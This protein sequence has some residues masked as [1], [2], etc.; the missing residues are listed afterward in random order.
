MKKVWMF[1]LALVFSA[2][3]ALAGGDVCRL[4]SEGLRIAKVDSAA[5]SMVVRTPEG[6]EMTI[7]WSD[8]TKIEG[9]LKEGETVRGQV[10]AKDGKLWASSLQVVPARRAS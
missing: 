1:A 8:A 5:R 6:R 3:V 9:A 10:S 4:A 2:A 7:H